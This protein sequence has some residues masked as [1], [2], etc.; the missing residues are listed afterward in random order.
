MSLQEFRTLLLRPLLHIKLSPFVLT[1]PLCLLVK[2]I[3][4]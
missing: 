1:A 4:P 2:A 3:D